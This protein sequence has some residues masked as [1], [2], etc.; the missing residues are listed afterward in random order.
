VLGSWVANPFLLSAA[1]PR[2]SLY[3]HVC[4]LRCEGKCFSSAICLAYA[5][6]SAVILLSDS[7]CALSGARRAQRATNRSLLLNGQRLPLTVISRCGRST[8]T[9]RARSRA[10]T[11]TRCTRSGS[12]LCASHRWAP[13]GHLL[14]PACIIVAFPT[15]NA[16]R[17]LHLFTMLCFVIVTSPL[18]DSGKMCS[19]V[20]SSVATARMIALLLRAT[21]AAGRRADVLRPRS[22]RTA[23]REAMIGSGRTWR[24]S[25]SPATAARSSSR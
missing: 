7:R 16:A 13:P 11:S 1:R 9:H 17:V 12:H 23:G 18:H 8:A 22:R 2:C 24:S 19:Q 14:R 6:R 3:F 20:S 21:W 10:T 4:Q 15:T 25:T 5:P